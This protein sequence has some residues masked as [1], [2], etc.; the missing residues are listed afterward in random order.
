MRGTRLKKRLYTV[1]TAAVANSQNH[2]YSLYCTPLAMCE[3]LSTRNDFNEIEASSRL[4]TALW[5]G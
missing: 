3:T 2:A 5:I 4:Q 1:Y